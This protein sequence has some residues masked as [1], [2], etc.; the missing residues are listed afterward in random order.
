MLLLPWYLYYQ[1]FLPTLH[2]LWKVITCFQPHYA[3]LLGLKGLRNHVVYRLLFRMVSHKLP[4]WYSLKPFL[5][6]AI[7]DSLNGNQCA[8][9]PLVAR[10]QHPCPLQSKYSANLKTLLSLFSHP[11][12]GVWPLLI[13][14]R[15][16]VLL[17]NLTAYITTHQKQFVSAKVVC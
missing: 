3:C 14:L 11:C 1:Y 5:F 9:E 8:I 10:L 13:M 4:L 12:V 2:V 16:H 7:N 17:P 15:S 6:S